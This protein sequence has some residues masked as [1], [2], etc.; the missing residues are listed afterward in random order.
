MVMVKETQTLILKMV[1][2]GAKM[3]QIRTTIMTRVE[4][5]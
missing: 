2:S 4:F 3:V 1:W 5:N